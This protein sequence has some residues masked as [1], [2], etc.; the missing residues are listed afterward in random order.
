MVKDQRTWL[1]DFLWMIVAAGIV[2]A[3][4]RFI[5]G[6]GS[7][8][9]LND[10]TPWGLWIAFKLGFVALAGGGFT[11]AAMVYIFHLETFR[12]IL[13]RAIL[14][15]LLGYGSFIVSLIFDLG[16]P[17]HIYMPII[18]WQHHSVMFEIA[19]CVMLYFSVLVMEFSP[20]ILEHP[21][22]QHPT[23]Q[24]IAHILHIATIPLVIAGIVLSTLHQSSL[25]SLFLI[26]PH[27]VHPLWYSPWIPVLFFIS[28]IAAGLMAL[29]I[30]SYFAKKLFNRGLHPDLLEK[31]GKIAGFVLILY[32][33]LRLGDLFYRGIL[34]T[35]LDGSWQSLYF[36]TEIF[37][38][39]FVPLIL[40]SIPRIRK[41][42]EGLITAA[43]LVVAGI[44]SQRMSL[45]MFTMWRPQG[46]PYTP[47]VLEVIIAFAIPAAAGLIYFLFNEQLAV[48]DTQLGTSPVPA[49]EL[50][51][52]NPATQS[53][54]P[55]DL[56]GQFVRR[57][58]FALL[59]I[60]LVYAM[61]P[62]AQLAGNSSVRIP[63]EKAIG[64]NVLQIDGNQRNIPV[65]FPHQEHQERLKEKFG[66]EAQACTQ[67]HHLSMPEDQYNACS[68]CHQDYLAP[69]SIFNHVKHVDQLGGNQACTECHQG[70]H[71]KETAVECRA[72]H[73]EMVPFGDNL[74][75]SQYAPGYKD[76]MHGVCLDCHIKEAEIQNIP[77]LG[78]C[79]T[80]HTHQDNLIQAAFIQ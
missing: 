66:T 53:Y 17:W 43:I 7:S 6:L 69:T 41:S 23:F 72:C 29:V 39:G 21:W 71:I 80:C 36:S 27:R 42:R 38:G 46:V 49:Q 35:A 24:K 79:S 47:S 45:S 58:G 76:A 40:M 63:V 54:R 65:S 44:L 34:P 3:A 13:R 18:S 2:A 20:V 25:G 78:E 32:L 14:L 37:L 5:N 26:M 56:F 64:W 59:A 67:C 51:V 1:K 28:A 22:F 33:A 31:L 77:D 50:P 60:G 9:G 16:L 57:S 55:M 75:F 8:T 74:A 4:I 48:L 70:E 11:L 68:E 10:G 62:S 19:W 12:P 73:E 52:Y 30:E 15:A 61:L